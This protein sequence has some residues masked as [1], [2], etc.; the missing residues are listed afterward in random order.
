M[1]ITKEQIKVINDFLKDQTFEYDHKPSFSNDMVNKAYYQ[2]HIDG[3]RQLISVGEMIDHIFVS[4]KLV[5]GEGIINLYLSHLGN[6]QKMTGRQNVANQ[7]FEF[8]V[9]IGQD[10]EDFLKLFNIKDPVVIDNFEFSP[11]EDFVSL[12]NLEDNK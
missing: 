6:K 1:G 3:V 7:W 2:F 10:I 8:Y 11:S 5:N 4:V 12:I 9:Q